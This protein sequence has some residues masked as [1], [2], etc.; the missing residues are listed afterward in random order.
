MDP[1][2]ED[3]RRFL[4]ATIRTVD[5]LELLR[6][7][8]EQPARDWTAEELGAALQIAPPAAAGHLADLLS[9]GLVARTAG[10]GP[11]AWRYGPATPDL[12]VG[13]ANLLLAYRERPVTMIKAVY[14]RPSDD[15][16]RSFADAFRLRKEGE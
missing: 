9:R 16:L 5:E 4:H 6:L 8:G 14:A 7:L 2:P 15:P 13:M 1:L 11:P 12:Q 3:V 10:G